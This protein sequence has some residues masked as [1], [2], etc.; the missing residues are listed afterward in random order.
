MVPDR[1]SV[2]GGGVAGGG[3]SGGGLVGEVVFF[4]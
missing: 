3:R 4:F 2:F 1:E